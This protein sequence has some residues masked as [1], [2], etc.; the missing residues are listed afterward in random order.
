M[1]DT[2][3]RLRRLFNP[4][5]GRC[6]DIAVD[7]GFFGQGSFLAGIEDLPSAVTALV[8]VARGHGLLHP[9]RPQLGGRIVRRFSAPRKQKAPAR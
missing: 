2:A 8:Q 5:S 6:L 7:H 1:S 9:E 3:Y 4:D